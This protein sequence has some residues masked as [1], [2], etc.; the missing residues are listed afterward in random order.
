MALLGAF[1]E[2]N[3]QENVVAG[4]KVLLQAKGSHRPG[5]RDCFRCD[6]ARVGQVVGKVLAL[7]LHEASVG[8]P[9]QEGKDGSVRNRSYP[10]QVTLLGHIT[11]LNISPSPGR[12]KAPN[13]VIL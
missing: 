10:G 9:D 2:W 12:V 8:A 7:E 5:I 11:K 4:E 1:F 13:F 6:W 3:V